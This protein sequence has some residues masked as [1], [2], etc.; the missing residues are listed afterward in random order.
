[1]K[2]NLNMKYFCVALILVVK[3]VASESDTCIKNAFD[4]YTSKYVNI[5]DSDLFSVHR[6]FSRK[7]KI[8][9]QSNMTVRLGI[10]F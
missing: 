2:N 10:N 5:T 7:P 8:K 1:M 4:D 6:T 9:K 3:T